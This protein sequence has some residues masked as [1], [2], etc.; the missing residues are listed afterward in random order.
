MTGRLA[1][2]R[3]GL[4]PTEGKGPNEHDI[5]HLTTY[6]DVSHEM[7][8]D[9]HLSSSGGKRGGSH[10][11]SGN[12]CLIVLVFFSGLGV[13]TVVAFSVSCMILYAFQSVILMIKFLRKLTSQGT[14]S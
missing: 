14:S 13:L 5:A 7:T 9:Q 10:P 8:G 2:S 4:Q 1:H 11:T 12:A 6:K 3:E